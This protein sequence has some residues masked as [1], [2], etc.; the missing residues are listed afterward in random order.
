VYLRMC[1]REELN[2]ESHP[3]PLPPSLFQSLSYNLRLRRSLP[4]QRPHRA[5]SSEANFGCRTRFII[6][7][8]SA[9]CAC[10]LIIIVTSGHKGVRLSSHHY[11]KSSR[12]TRS[13][14]HASIHYYHYIIPRPESHTT[15]SPPAA[16]P[17]RPPID[18]LSTTPLHAP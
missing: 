6:A 8:A 15:A 14:T 2:F 1:C 4:R 16:T 11:Y 3:N 18:R 5:S 12:N 7:F 10:L 13:G 9:D 17:H